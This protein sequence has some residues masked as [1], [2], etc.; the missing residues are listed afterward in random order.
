MD[1]YHFLDRFL[2][3][4]HEYLLLVENVSIDLDE[5][6]VNSGTFLRESPHSVANDI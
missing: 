6:D 3:I 1:Q 2:W 4:D 5:V